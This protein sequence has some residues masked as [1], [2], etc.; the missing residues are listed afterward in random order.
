MNVYFNVN[1]QAQLVVISQHANS[2]RSASTCSAI[3]LLVD[4]YLKVRSK[5]VTPK[6]KSLKLRHILSELSSFRC[7]RCEFQQNPPNS[8]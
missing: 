1:C 2:L 7:K 4:T 5:K 3:Q 8:I 6:F